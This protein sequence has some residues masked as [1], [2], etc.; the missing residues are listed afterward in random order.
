MVD[1]DAEELDADVCKAIKIRQCGCILLD[2]VYQAHKNL[3]KNYFFY[4][5]RA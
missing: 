5:M 1:I 2:I 4:E 3:E